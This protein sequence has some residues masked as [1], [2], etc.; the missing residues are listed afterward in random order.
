MLLRRLASLVLGLAVSTSLATVST[1]ALA[2]PSLAD[3]MRQTTASIDAMNQASLAVIEAR[4]AYDAQLAA[5]AEAARAI[6]A[7]PAPAKPVVFAPKPGSRI[8]E[9]LARPTS[10]LEQLRLVDPDSTSIYDSLSF[11]R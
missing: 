6:F 5:V 3:L 9:L 10:R 2:E 1:T 4:Q 7:A 11:E 8:A